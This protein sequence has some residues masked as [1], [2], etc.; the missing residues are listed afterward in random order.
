M[1]GILVL[2]EEKWEEANFL[3]EQIKESGHE[4]VIMDIG[5]IDEPQGPC[6]ITREEIIMSLRPPVG[7]KECPSW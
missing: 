2:A 1:I 6:D 5:L 3:R 7:G 4:G